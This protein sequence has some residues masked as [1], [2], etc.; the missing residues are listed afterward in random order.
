MTLQTKQKPTATPATGPEAEASARKA[1][2]SDAILKELG[3][4]K[5]DKKTSLET[6]KRQILSRCGCL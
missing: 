4:V 3:A 1:P 2:S 5:V 6:K